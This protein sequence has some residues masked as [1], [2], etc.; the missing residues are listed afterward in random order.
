MPTG[1]RAIQLPD[2]HVKSE[3]M[4]SFGRPARQITCDCERSQEPSMTQALLF[5][6]G[7][8]INRKVTADGGLVDRLIA[9]GKTDPQILDTLYWTALGRAPSPTEREESLSAVHKV[10]AAPTAPPA[11]GTAPA[12][13]ASHVQAPAVVTAASTS[14]AQTPST[15]PT[16][17]PKTDGP[18]RHAFEDLLWVLVNSKEFLFNH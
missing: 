12:A 17:A 15:A 7:D 18:R 3:F 6:N 5:I 16:E 14:P 1:F 11:P 8:L 13:S 9:A 2:T 10:L 4:D